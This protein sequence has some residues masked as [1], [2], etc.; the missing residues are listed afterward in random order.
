MVTSVLIR[1][2]Q[3]DEARHQERQ[4]KHARNRLKQR[5]RPGLGRDGGDIPGECSRLE[6]TRERGNRTLILHKHP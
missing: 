3:G 5:H 4:K 1:A 2:V 6:R